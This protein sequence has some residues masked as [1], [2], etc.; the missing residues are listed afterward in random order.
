MLK[1]KREKKERK[2]PRISLLF[3]LILIIKDE[4]SNKN[5][6][7]INDKKSHS[8]P[9]VS[10]APKLGRNPTSRKKSELI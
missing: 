3:N 9:I 1:K 4:F 7:D 6:N 10:I 2:I 8:K 5:I